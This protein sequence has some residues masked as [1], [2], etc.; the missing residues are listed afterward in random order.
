MNRINK[1][2][3]HL[4]LLLSIGFL[5]QSN[6]SHAQQSFEVD[7]LNWEK[8]V[9]KC[10][11]SKEL[12]SEDDTSKDDEFTKAPERKSFNFDGLSASFQIFAWVFIGLIII[13]L[14]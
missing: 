14:I 2:T 8:Q 3:Y 11:F 10:D 13:L 7:S 5:L 1:K 12:E 9:Q 4:F 6:D